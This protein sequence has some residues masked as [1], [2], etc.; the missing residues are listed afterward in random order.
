[1]EPPYWPGC[2]K[3]EQHASLSA[4]EFPSMP[5]KHQGPLL[6]N[7]GTTSHRIF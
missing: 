7:P 5:T 4:K 1:M 3:G 6:H 2:K